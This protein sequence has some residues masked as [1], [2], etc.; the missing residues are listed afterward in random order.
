MKLI[1]INFFL[2][3]EQKKGD[4]IYVSG[5]LGLA[6]LGLKI[7]FEEKKL[8][9]KE[10]KKYVK[11]FFKPKVHT[12]TRKKLKKHCNSCIDIS[13]GLIGDLGHICQ[14]SKLGARIDLIRYLMKD[15]TK[16]P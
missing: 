16:M 14:Q 5:T 12:C 4:S 7:K 2:G 13:D 11:N 15:L 10:E 9:T 8:N 1:V 3:T 6:K